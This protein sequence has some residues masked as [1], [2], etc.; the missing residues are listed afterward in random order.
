M[1]IAVLD[2]YKLFT[3]L[4]VENSIKVLSKC[5]CAYL[6][7]LKQTVAKSIKHLEIE[8]LLVAYQDQLRLI[9]CDDTI[10]VDREV[11][12]VVELNLMQLSWDNGDI[13]C[14]LLV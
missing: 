4:R 6:T 3:N 13:H 9:F 2:G 5:P 1:S 8:L 14:F 7:V 10:L 12:S 11:Q